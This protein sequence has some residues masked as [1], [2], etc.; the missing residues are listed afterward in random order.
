[1]ISS[2]CLFLMGSLRTTFPE[3]LFPPYP[4]QAMSDFCHPCLPNPPP[5]YI[6]HKISKAFL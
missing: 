2:Y 6:L 5:N 4:D 1:M 3:H